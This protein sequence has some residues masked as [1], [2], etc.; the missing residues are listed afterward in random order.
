MTYS[1]SVLAAAA[2]LVSLGCGVAQAALPEITAA[3]SVTDITPNAADCRG[4]YGD[5]LLSGNSSAI[6]VQMQA[7][8]ELGYNWDGNFAGVEKI[9]GLNGTHSVDFSTMMSDFTYIGLHFGGGTGSPTPGQDSTAFYKLNA[10]AG[11]DIIT[12]AFNA[13]SDAVLYSTTPVPSVPEPET[14]ALMLAG[15]GAV[16]FMVRRRRAD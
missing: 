13:S 2:V 11:L 10:G 16:G 12:L 9:S 14:Y 7:L 3:C 15:L 1:R 6:D 4:F 8:A 5:Q